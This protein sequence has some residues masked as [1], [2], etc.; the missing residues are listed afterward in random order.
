M[1]R[2][3]GHVGMGA[4]GHA[5]ARG[6]MLARGHGDKGRGTVLGGGWRGLNL[7]LVLNS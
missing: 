5:L 3:R 6:G 4:G 7:T 1:K 2:E